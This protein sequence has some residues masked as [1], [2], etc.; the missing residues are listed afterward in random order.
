MVQRGIMVV[1]SGPSGAGKGAVR[2]RL[3]ERHPEVRY[4]VSATT[5]HPRMGEVEGQSYHF[6][7]RQ[8]FE[9]RI[10]LG[11]FVEWAEVYG[12]LYGT[13]RQ[14]AES[15]LV[16]GHDVVVE[17][18]I[19]G[20]L[21]L[22]EVYPD[23]V[24]VFILPPSME[25]L[26][27]R[28]EQRGSETPESRDRRLACAAGEMAYIGR[29]DYAVINDQLDAAVDKLEAIMTAEKCRVGRQPDL[30]GGGEP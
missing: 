6:L 11:D 24:F 12:N 8:D 30:A 29:Y 19:Q 18:D 15:W 25:A 26:R 14:P 7:S 17:K 3:R 27:Q 22:K 9:D 4:G 23:A 28:I 2:A 5:R 16:A 20:A 10:A 1:L 21:K 13:P